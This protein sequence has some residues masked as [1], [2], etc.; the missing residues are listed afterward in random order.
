MQQTLFLK[1]LLCAKSGTA[2]VNPQVLVLVL[3]S[4]QPAEEGLHNPQT[5][6]SVR[7]KWVVL[8]GKLERL[9]GSNGIRLGAMTFKLRRKGCAGLR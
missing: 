9:R 2:V 3:Q 8:T 5:V 4:L 1:H 7:G 6:I